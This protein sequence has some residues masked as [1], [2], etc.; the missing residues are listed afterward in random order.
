[1]K[2]FKY[3]FLILI[4]PLYSISQ[5]TLSYPVDIVFHEEAEHYYVTNWADT[6]AGYILKLNLDGDVIEKYVDDLNY[7]GGLCLVDNVLYFTDNLSIWG[8]DQQPSYIKGIDLNSGN[9]VLNFE[10]STGNTYLDLIDTDGNGNLFIGNTR[11]GGSNGIVHKFNIASQ[12]LTDLATQ[13]LKPFGV[14]YDNINDRVIFTHSQSSV[15]YLKS[16]SPE[17]G[18]ITTVFYV[19]GYLEGVIMHPDGHFYISSWGTLDGIWG[20]EPVYKSNLVNSWKYEI[21]ND[22]NRPFGMCVGY[23]NHLVVCNWGSHSLNFIDLDLFGV[24]DNKLADQNINIYPNPSNGYFTISLKDVKEKEIDLTITDITGQKV[25]SDQIDDGNFMIDKA[26][27]LRHL[28]SGTY[29]L[30]LRGRNSVVQGKLIIY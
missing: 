20:N 26:Y 21:S 10:V 1:M 18:D 17:G 15:S 7:P 4:L 6:S 11:S 25:F 12:E 8:S 30:I 27:D 24:D 14:C 5:D 19:E 9:Q 13:I 16:I 22:N 28:P 29:I 2:Y 23:D 3:I